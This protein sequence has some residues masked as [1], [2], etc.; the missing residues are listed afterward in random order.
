MT[1]VDLSE[2][3]LEQA[4]LNAPTVRFF[5]QDMRGLDVEGSP[6]DAVACLFDSI[7]YALDDA[8]VLATLGAMRRHAGTESALVIEFLHAPAL[9]AAASPTRV[10]RSRA[11]PR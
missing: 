5:Q 2:E 1:G 7:G 9:L 11:A 3:L 4:R 8:G 10:R 6:F